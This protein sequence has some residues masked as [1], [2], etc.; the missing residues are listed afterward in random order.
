MRSQ[1][2]RHDDMLRSCLRAV[3]GVASLPGIE[4]CAP[5]SSFMRRTV[6][7]PQLKDKYMQVGHTCCIVFGLQ[8]TY[9]YLKVGYMRCYLMPFIMSAM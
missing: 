1:L 2:D 8:L 3:H 4:G 7:A 9:Q 6:M 5:F